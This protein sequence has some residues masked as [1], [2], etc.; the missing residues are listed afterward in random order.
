VPSVHHPNSPPVCTRAITTASVFLW[1]SIPALLYWIPDKGAATIA[2]KHL[3]F[4]QEHSAP[5]MNEL[6]LW[7]EA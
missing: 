6:H 5:L 1:T 4:H 3:L 7:M 2:G